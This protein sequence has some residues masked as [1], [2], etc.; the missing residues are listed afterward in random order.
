MLNQIDQEL[1]KLLSKRIALLREA[2][3]KGWLSETVDVTQLLDQFGVPE[4]IW[5]NL[6]L[7]CAAASNTT[8]SSTRLVKPRRITIIGGRGKMGN[9]FNQQLSTAGHQVS[10]LEQDDWGDATQRLGKAELVLICVPIEQTRTTIEK[11]APY[12]ASS[13]I[14]ADITSLK[15]TV[16]P[17]MLEHHAGPVLS[18]HPMFGPGVESFLSQ[19]VVVCPVRRQEAYQWFLDFIKS[20]GGKLIFCT[21]QEHDRMMVNIQAIR[22]FATFSFGVFL[23]KEGINITRSLDFTSPLYRLQIDIVSRLFAQNP[24]L[25]LNMMLSSEE[26]RQAIGRLAATYNR[27][28]QLI[29]QQNQAA[30]EQEFEATSDFFQKEGDRALKESNYIIDSLSLLLAAHE[31]EAKRDSNSNSLAA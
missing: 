12:L 2:T 9:F 1:I 29:T 3:L 23:C 27:L 5:K 21:P 4:F 15:T 30:L 11:A 18:L 22:H 20:K 8:Y 13:T 24:S 25:S 28:A 16:V 6:M 19:N 7:S 14:L 17:A 26:R 10:I 31:T